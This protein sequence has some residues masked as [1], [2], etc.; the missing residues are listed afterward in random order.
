[1]GG[2]NVHGDEQSSTSTTERKRWY[3]SPKIIIGVAVL[4]AVPIVGTTLAATNN[5]N[6]QINDHNLITLGQGAA[7]ALACDTHVVVRPH[8]TYDDGWRVD[9]VV[10]EDLNLNPK[11]DISGEGCAGTPL[12][13]LA[14]SGVPDGVAADGSS[15]TF[16]ISNTDGSLAIDPEQY[17][18]STWS[19]GENFIITKGGTLG[20]AS[21]S[22]V[23]ITYGGLGAP[24]L[25]GDGNPQ[26]G[27]FALSEG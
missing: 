24:T 15:T 9:Y 20:D 13:L 4:V 7:A 18:A 11:G 2:L 1:M 17:S 16:A 21:S 26:I 22:T 19:S 23:K 14:T 12:T 6:V 25:D 8:Q 10:I 27:A 5:G 3:K